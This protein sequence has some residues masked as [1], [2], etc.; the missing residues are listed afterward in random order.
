[1]TDETTGTARTL[2]EQFGPRPAW[3]RR[4]EVERQ[5]RA[6][7]ARLLLRAQGLD[8]K[9]ERGSL[10]EIA[11]IEQSLISMMASEEPLA[12]QEAARR[13]ADALLDVGEREEPTFWSTHLGRALSREIGYVTPW[14]PHD[15][16]R[17]VLHVSRQAID[18]MAAKGRLD[19]NARLVSRESLQQAAAARWPHGNDV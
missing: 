11:R 1:M 14:A 10:F 8:V 19:M 13:I 2:P 18:Q 17:N 9:L 16:A 15:V 5:I 7:S 12:R 4:A 3:L 6:L